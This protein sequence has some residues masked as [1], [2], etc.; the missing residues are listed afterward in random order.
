MVKIFVLVIVLLSFGCSTKSYV[1]R[2]ENCDCELINRRL[3]A[4]IEKFNDN[5]D[6]LTQRHNKTIQEISM[7]QH[8]MSG[9]NENVD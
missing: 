6:G 9:A 5:I 4:I 7:S 3:I 8:K 2:T 1:I